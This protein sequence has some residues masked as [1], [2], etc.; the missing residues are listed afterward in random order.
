MMS[1]IVQNVV[2]GFVLSA[3][4]GWRFALARA[5]HL[6]TLRAR[7]QTQNRARIERL[8]WLQVARSPRCGWNQSLV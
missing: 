7:M 8:W 5:R 6:Q 1:L 2:V 3:K 4:F